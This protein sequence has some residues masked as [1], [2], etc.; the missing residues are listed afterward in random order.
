MW[1]QKFQ[2]ATYHIRDLQESLKTLKYQLEQA[3]LK[4]EEKSKQVSMRENELAEAHQELRDL[5]QNVGEL[6]IPPSER[7]NAKVRGLMGESTDGIK[8]ITD[9]FSAAVIPLILR[10]SSPSTK[11]FGDAFVNL[12][13][14]IIEHG[15]PSAQIIAILVKYGGNGPI[16]K[17]REMIRSDDFDDVIEQLAKQKLIAVNNGNVRILTEPVP[18]NW[19]ELPTR[20]IFDQ[21]LIQSKR[22]EINSMAVLEEV[23]DILLERELPF[24]TFFFEVRKIIERIERDQ[25]NSEELEH[26]IKIWREKFITL[27]S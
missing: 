5:R 22:G 21:L 12:V 4:I 26:Q 15:N 9:E 24:S 10:E 19:N 23:R 7:K 25:I 18:I 20:E 17:V 13:E 27:S 2:E 14:M 3:Q 16:D 8:I 11:R 1:K 6:E